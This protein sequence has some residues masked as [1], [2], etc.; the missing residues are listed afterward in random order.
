M[1]KN[2]KGMIANLIAGFVV[3]LIGVSLLPMISKQLETIQSQ[4]PTANVTSSATTSLEFTATLL[5]FVP[6]FFAL[7]IL[8]VAIA[9][10]SS[11]LKSAGVFGRKEED[12]TT[13]KEITKKDRYTIPEYKTPK[14]EYDENEDETPAM[15]PLTYEEKKKTY[16]EKMESFNKKKPLLEKDLEKNL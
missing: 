9:M 16:N 14:Y 3:I 5:K 6:A 13:I 7:A 15:D 8:G 1:K 4:T 11:A 12:E 10:I 2:K